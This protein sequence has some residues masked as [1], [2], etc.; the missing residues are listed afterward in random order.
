MCVGIEFLPSCRQDWR[1]H[2]STGTALQSHYPVLCL[3]SQTFLHECIA[4][5]KLYRGCSWSFF[6][7]VVTAWGCRH[8]PKF[9]LGDSGLCVCQWFWDWDDVPGSFESYSWINCSMAST[10]RRPI[11]RRFSLSEVWMGLS[12]DGSFAT[13]IFTTTP[14]VSQSCR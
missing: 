2:Y 6:S 4:S 3:K 10:Q 13:S 12:S 14:N 7:S 1:M 5:E 8:C 9:M 11:S